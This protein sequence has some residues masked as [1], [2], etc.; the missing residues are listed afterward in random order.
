[1]VTTKLSKQAK[2]LMDSA[3]ALDNAVGIKYGANSDA[4]WAA[5]H[6]ACYAFLAFCEVDKAEMEASERESK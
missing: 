3:E 2:A 1:M 6:L 4:S 5:T